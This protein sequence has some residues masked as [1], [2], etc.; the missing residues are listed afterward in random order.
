M[1]SQSGTTTVEDGA[2]L[3][4]RLTTLLVRDLA[5]VLPAVRGLRFTTYEDWTS[6]DAVVAGPLPDEI[7]CHAGGA[8]FSVSTTGGP[9]DLLVQLCSRLQDE[10]MDHLHGAWPAV[11]VDRRRV[12]LAPGLDELGRAVWAAPG[13]PACPV[14]YLTHALGRFLPLTVL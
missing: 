6:P 9:E 14:G 11:E 13:G 5:E 2:V 10:V 8:S 3:V 7:V 4:D 1:T 12:V